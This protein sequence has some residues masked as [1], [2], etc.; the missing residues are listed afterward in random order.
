MTY[1]YSATGERIEDDLPP[2]A[3]TPPAR[4]VNG[5]DPV[6][7]ARCNELRQILRDARARREV[8]S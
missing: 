2:G 1:H 3:N 8:A 4:E 6:V 5:R 7:V